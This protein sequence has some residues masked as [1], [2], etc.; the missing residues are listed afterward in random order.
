MD[1]RLSWKQ[2]WILRNDSIYRFW[3]HAF[4]LRCWQF[5]IS[6]LCTILLSGIGSCGCN[7][8]AQGKHNNMTR[9]GNKQKHNSPTLSKGAGL[10]WCAAIYSSENSNHG[11]CVAFHSGGG[12]SW[13]SGSHT[14]LGGRTWGPLKICLELSPLH[15]PRGDKWL[16]SE[17]QFKAFTIRSV[18]EGIPS[19]LWTWRDPLLLGDSNPIGWSRLVRV[20]VSVEGAG[21]GGWA[22]RQI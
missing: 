7:M 15:G 9:S 1:Y 12:R 20:C 18:R 2:C 14:N 17:I 4:F 22:G 19:V 10:L 3:S 21:G 6:Y 5:C 16:I 11:S 8:R 13:V